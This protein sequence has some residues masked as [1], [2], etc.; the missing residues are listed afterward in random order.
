[1]ALILALLLTLALAF[2][3]GDDRSRRLP[4]KTVPLAASD[5]M[6]EVKIGDLKG[7]QG[8]ALVLPI[9]AVDWKIERAAGASGRATFSDISIVKKTDAATPKLALLVANGVHIDDPVVIETFK[10][11]TK[12]PYFVLKL[13][14]VIVSSIQTIDET[15]ERVGFEYS[16]ITFKYQPGIGSP[17]SRCWDLANNLTCAT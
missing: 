11:G 9:S 4:S 13:E 7:G 17:I 15:R 5:P 2:A 8:A 16:Q 1:M 6:G 3:G 14:E 12:Q 10:P